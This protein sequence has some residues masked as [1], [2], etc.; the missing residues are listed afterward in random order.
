MKIVDAHLHL[1][2]INDKIILNYMRQNLAAAVSWAYCEPRPQTFADLARYFAKQQSFAQNCTAQGLPCFRLAGVH[3]RNIPA[4]ET[5]TQA[6]INALLE[7]QLGQIYGIGEMGLETGTAEEED[8]LAMQLDFARRHNLKACVHTPRKN[9]PERL[10][11]T[12]KLI[13]QSGLKPANVL[14]DHL[15]TPSMVQTVVSLGYYA[16]ITISPAKSNFNDVL[17]ILS[18]TPDNP[19][20]IMLNS[21]L[22]S[23]KLT[24]YEMFVES[25]KRLPREYEAVGAQ[26]ALNFF[27]IKL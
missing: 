1:D 21:D 2:F 7:T 25:V 11:P 15:N 24:D 20:Q 9:K 27:N 23:P 16:G 18:Q 14:V 4:E 17:E 6:K 5:A 8:V 19:G 22:V 12:L 3:P 10:T 26:N 13:G